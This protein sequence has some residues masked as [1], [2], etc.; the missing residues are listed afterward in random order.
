M[1]TMLVTLQQML[2]E[3]LT[4]NDLLIGV[5][6]LVLLSLA[7]MLLGTGSGRFDKQIK[8][9]HSRR[10]VLHDEAMAAKHR[11][12]PQVHVSF[13]RAIAQKLQLVK[14]NQMGKTQQEL[15]QAGMRSKDAIY[16][17]A[18]FNVLMPL[19]LFGVGIVIMNMNDDVS[20][21][22]RMMNYIW[23]VL[24]AYIGLKL[25]L[26]YVR[27]KKKARNYRIQK[28][29][30]D[31]LD[32]MTICA[33]AGLSM[34]AMLDRVARELKEVYPEMA[35]ELTLTSLEIGFLPERS[36]ALLNFS[37]RCDL[38][39]IRGMMSVLIQTE[40]YG[41]P[42]AQALRVLSAE[43]RQARMLRAEQKA[44]RLPAVMTV[45]MI[46]FIL[47]TLFIVI[48]APAVVKLMAGAAD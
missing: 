25:P 48:I 45:P 37:E 32:L 16:V 7:W 47:P 5:L 17:L 35:E 44:A 27:K 39:E 19:L 26:Y 46:V 2:P 22:W 34:V 10:E 40:K 15:I 28:S 36:R 41:T 1:E 33:E 13:M 20:P 24:G 21:K 18:F 43:F 9:I 23:P 14:K 11:T 8:N 3:W 6:V 42:I 12:K 4:P 30:P 31:V 38:A 29:L